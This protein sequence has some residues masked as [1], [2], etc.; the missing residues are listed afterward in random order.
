MRPTTVSRL[1]KTFA[2]LLLGAH[3]ALAHAAQNESGSMVTLF[4]SLLLILSGFVLIAWLA[5]RYLPG[6]GSRGVVKVV[7]ANPGGR[8]RAGGGDR[9]GQ[10][11]AVAGRGRRTGAVAGQDAQAGRAYAR[12][13]K[14]GMK[15]MSFTLNIGSKAPGFQ[16]KATD[17]K[18]YSCRILMKAGTWW[19]FL[20]ATIVPMYWDRMRLPGKLPLNM[21]PKGVRFVAINSNSANTYREDDFDHMVKQDGTISVSLGFTCMMRPRKLP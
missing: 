3:P 18:I 1:N 7:G 8:A 13:G 12:F 2:S 6:A 21:R 15:N 10:Y 11:L 20:P 17:G 14:N 5:R 9:G 4:L 19:C 16:L